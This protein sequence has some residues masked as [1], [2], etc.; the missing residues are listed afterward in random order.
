MPADPAP[1]A[2]KDPSF[3]FCLWLAVGLAVF[4]VL[5]GDCQCELKISPRPPE[6]RP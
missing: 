2:R 5:G 3:V 4:A 1:A 6:T